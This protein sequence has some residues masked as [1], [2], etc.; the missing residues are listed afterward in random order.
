MNDIASDLPEIG[1]PAT[2]A[3]A[4]IGVTQLEQLTE[5]TEGE[6]LDL[7]GFGPRALDIVKAALHRDGQQLRP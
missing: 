3:L 2:R 1:G 6:L 7:H 4:S 5:H